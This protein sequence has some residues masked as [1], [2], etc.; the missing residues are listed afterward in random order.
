MY[1]VNSRPTKRNLKIWRRK[2]CTQCKMVFTTYE[3]VDPSFLFV[4]KKSGRVV[5]FSRPK[6]F[7]SIYKAAIQGKHVDHGEMSILT[8]EITQEVEV[9]ILNQKRKKIPTS[10]IINIVVEVLK[11]R[12]LNILFRYLSYFENISKNQVLKMLS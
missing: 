1:T 12:N 11:K 3:S 5:R 8:E 9:D 10:E 4:V 7:S 6:L 2:K